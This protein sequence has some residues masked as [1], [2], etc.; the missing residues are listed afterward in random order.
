MIYSSLVQFSLILLWE[1]TYFIDSSFLVPVQERGWNR[2]NAD[3]QA[4]LPSTRSEIFFFFSQILFLEQL[5]ET[6]LYL[7]GTFQFNGA[8]ERG[9]GDVVGE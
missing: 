8:R 5:L 7:I 2:R 4:L 6:R 9:G 1:P 3:P